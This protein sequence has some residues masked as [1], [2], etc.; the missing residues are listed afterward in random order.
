MGWKFSIKNGTAKV[1]RGKKN[2]VKQCCRFENPPIFLKRRD[3]QEGESEWLP[4]K[5]TYSS[6]WNASD[7]TFPMGL[8][9]HVRAKLTQQGGA[10]KIKGLK[11]NINPNVPADYCFTETAR[12]HQIVAVRKMLARKCGSIEVATGGG[13]TL[14]MAMTAAWFVREYG[15]RVLVMVPG[16]DLLNQTFR[17][18]QKYINGGE[19]GDVSIGRIGDGF[20][21][22]GK[23]I[24][25]GIAASLIRGVP[26]EDD[27]GNAVV[28]NE[29]AHKFLHEQDVLLVDECQ[30]VGAE[31][32]FWSGIETSAEYSYAF[33]GTVETG[34]TLKDSRRLALCGPIRYRVPAKE[35]I[36]KGVLANPTIYFLLDD[37]IY[38]L[39]PDELDYPKAYK[40]GI[41]KD[42]RYNKYVARLTANLVEAKRQV[43]V[44]VRRRS[45]GRLLMQMLAQLNID[46]R[47]VDGNMSTSERESIKYLFKSRHLQV[48]VVVKVFDAGIDMPLAD[49]LIL[50]GGEKAHIGLKQRIGR[51]LRAT[52]EKNQ[53]AVFDFSHS[54]HWFLVRHAVMRMEIYEKEKF[55]VVGIDDQFAMLAV[56]RR[57]NAILKPKPNLEFVCGT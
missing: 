42:R 11:S 36:E 16:K 7:Q 21:E 20:K 53:A 19:S 32:W 39:V 43:I 31:T 5:W 9:E 26:K 30:S 8:T 45:Q 18:F 37:D 49:A 57:K 50:A 55:D 47:Y 17:D 35:L 54:S 15:K 23:S 46:S 6:Y 10:V 22:Y 48:I 25:I 13:K 44:N 3:P 56:A 1:V 27:N 4:P 2:A 51:V 33:S 29:D 52:A 38:G 40:A 28:R 34:N 41:V 12:T 14:I 24:T